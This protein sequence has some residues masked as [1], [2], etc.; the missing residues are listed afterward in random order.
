M[1]HN[2]R[3]VSDRQLLLVL[4]IWALVLVDA[5]RQGILLPTSELAATWPSSPSNVILLFALLGPP[6]LVALNH[7][8]PTSWAGA[9]ANW[10]QR[11]VDRYFG[12]GAATRFWYRLQ[13]LYLMSAGSFLLG[14]TSY[15]ASERGGAPAGAFAISII[16]IT[17]GVGFLL[18]ALL[19]LFVLRRRH[20]A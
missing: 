17:F 16:F 7:Y 6:I 18:G 1:P 13:P 11:L 15:I 5:T 20:A 9:W 10:P 3:L 19:E 14:C 2:G 12:S 8:F 4:A